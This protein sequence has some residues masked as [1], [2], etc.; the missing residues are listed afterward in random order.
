MLQ[1]SPGLR[2]SL[3]QLTDFRYGLR[4]QLKSCPPVTHELRG[5]CEDQKG[6]P[7]RVPDDP[8]IECLA[9]ARNTFK[10]AKIATGLIVRPDQFILV[11]LSC[12]DSVCCFLQLICSYGGVSKFSVSLSIAICRHV[13]GFGRRLSRRE[14]AFCFLIEVGTECRECGQSGGTRRQGLGKSS[15]CTEQF[16]TA[17]SQ[18]LC[19]EA[20]LTTE[21]VACQATRYRVQEFRPGVAVQFSSINVFLLP[22][23]RRSFSSL[24]SARRRVAPIRRNFPSCWK[25]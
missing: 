8:P 24:P 9:R 25:S 3:I 2:V 15:S 14:E 16:V 7:D 17:L 6:P 19:G 13:E 5:I 20:K 4:V 10:T 12:G 11:G 18:G 22:L 21:G 23:R 1:W